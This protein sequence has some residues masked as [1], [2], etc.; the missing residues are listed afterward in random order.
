M[1]DSFFR[2]D[3]CTPF[4]DGLDCVVPAGHYFVLG[5][6]RDNSADSRSWGMVPA[7]HIVGKV[8]EAFRGG[9]SQEQRQ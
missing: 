9:P 6:N 4:P 3:A 5:D 7:D 2:R 1:S 8:I